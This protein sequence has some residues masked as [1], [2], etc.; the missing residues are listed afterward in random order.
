M[1]TTAKVFKNGNSTA[2]RIPAAFGLKPGD[3]ME[4]IAAN[5]GSVVMR[6]RTPGLGGLVEA[7]WGLPDDF[8]EGGRDDTPPQERDWDAIERAFSK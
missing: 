5:D 7:L 6:K 4:L 8:M 3:E 2:V 1:T